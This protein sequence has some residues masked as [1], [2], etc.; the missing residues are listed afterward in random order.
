MLSLRSASVFVT[1]LQ[2][3]VAHKG[4]S[5]FRH[6]DLFVSFLTLPFK[7]LLEFHGDGATQLSREALDLFIIYTK[8]FR[9]IHLLKYSG[10]T[11]IS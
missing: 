7:S 3:L 10:G 1:H 11:A 8:L 6:F 2:T 4:T 5:L 9:E